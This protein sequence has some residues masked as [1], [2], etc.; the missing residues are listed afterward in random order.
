MDLPILSLTVVTTVVIVINVYHPS[1]V[2]CIPILR[3]PSDQ[4]PSS[5][6]NVTS[7]RVRDRHGDT[8][9]EI[10][11]TEAGKPREETLQENSQGHSGNNGHGISEIPGGKENADQRIRE[12]SNSSAEPDRVLEEDGHGKR[13]N[14]DPAD[15]HGQQE[16]LRHGKLE[17]EVNQGE[18]PHTATS[19]ASEHVFDS[20]FLPEG[21]H[22]ATSEVSE[23]VSDSEVL[24]GISII[25]RNGQ[26]GSWNR[27]SGA[28]QINLT[29]RQENHATSRRTEAEETDEGDGGRTIQ[30]EHA[31]EHNDMMD[32]LGRRRD[33][34]SDIAEPAHLEERDDETQYST[35]RAT[36]VP[37]ARTISHSRTISRSED[38]F[39]NNLPP[40]L[41]HSIRTQQTTSSAASA[42]RIT[43]SDDAGWDASITRRR[44]EESATAAPPVLHLVETLTA[45]HPSLTIRTAV[46]VTSLSTSL[47]RQELRTQDRGPSTERGGLEGKSGEISQAGIG[48]PLL[49]FNPAER[50]TSTVASVSA[51]LSF[52]TISFVPNEET[53]LLPS[54]STSQATRADLTTTAV[55]SDAH[56]L[57]HTVDDVHPPDLYS[58]A[59]QA[60]A[61]HPTVDSSLYRPEDYVH[62][63]GEFSPS[64][65]NDSAAQSGSVSEATVAHDVNVTRDS[66]QLTTV[67]VL[68]PAVS[69]TDVPRMDTFRHVTEAV[70]DENSGSHR[71][72]G[73]IND[74]TS[75][76]LQSLHMTTTQPIQLALPR[77]EAPSIDHP[78]VLPSNSNATSP[79]MAIT[80][81]TITSSTIITSTLA[82]IAATLAQRAS[83]SPGFAGLSSSRT[84]STSTMTSLP[85]A[86]SAVS[87]TLSASV[88]PRARASLSPVSTAEHN[89]SSSEIADGRAGIK[90]DGAK[91]AGEEGVSTGSARNTSDSPQNSNVNSTTLGA[92]FP[93]RLSTLAQRTESAMKRTPTLPTPRADMTGVSVNTRGAEHILLTQTTT[94]SQPQREEGDVETNTVDVDAQKKVTSGNDQREGIVTAATSVLF[95]TALAQGSTSPNRSA[96]SSPRSLPSTRSDSTA[97]STATRSNR[98]RMHTTFIIASTKNSNFTRRFSAEGLTSQATLTT[99]TTSSITE[100]GGVPPGLEHNGPFYIEIKLQMTWGQFCDNVNTFRLEIVSIVRQEIRQDS[101]TGDQIRLLESPRK[102]CALQT[103]YRGQSG[104]LFEEEQIEIQLYLVNKTYHYDVMLTYNCGLILRQGFQLL[105]ES[106]FKDKLILV[107]L[108]ELSEQDGLET[109]TPIIVV[110]RQDDRDKDTFINVPGVTIVISIAAVGGICCATLIIIQVVLRRRHREG[111]RVFNR[112]YSVTSVDSI[113]LNNVTKSRPNSGLFNPALDIAPERLPKTISHLLNF[114]EL[115]KFAFNQESIFEEFQRITNKTPRLSVVP[116]GAEDKNRFANILPIASTRVVLN[117][118]DGQD[119]VAAYINGN[120]VSGYSGKVRAYVAT[121]APLDNTLGDLWLMVW[122]HDTKTLVMLINPV[123]DGNK[124]CGTYFPDSVGPE[125]AVVCGDFSITMTKRDVHQ[126]Y[127]TSWLQVKM[128]KTKET[129]NVRHFWLTCWPASGR[130]DPISLVRFVLDSRPHYEDSGSPLLVHCSNGIARTGTFIALDICMRQFE[131][132]RTVDVMSCVNAMRHERAGCV[133]TSEQYAILYQALYEYATILTCP[134]AVSASS[135]AVTLT[136]LTS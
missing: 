95:T 1:A 26:G 21:A 102:A 81:T 123:E 74:R 120:Y 47:R 109:P 22:T 113:A 19:P 61:S 89:A 119:T 16:V 84:A 59:S 32:G 127:I 108:H 78:V 106:L 131:D 105:E 57:N 135:S 31:G 60:S 90:S 70:S 124:K 101:F 67:L 107:R 43:A 2:H 25:K 27:A 68:R 24:P 53:P 122:Q 91:E 103:S 104:G 77:T 117:V 46:G 94:G 132:R 52:S 15:V 41:D 51:V 83:T 134:P 72:A 98:S 79:F 114:N 99:R 18:D 85:S 35:G 14:E 80:I 34:G 28:V 17:D 100:A 126:E 93:F 66:V 69:Q 6:N 82:H 64:K 112:S 136:A 125:C 86:T 42:L 9:H 33:T 133:Q 40:V 8:A 38:I 76:S 63:H 44:P 115:V 39:A 20:E 75:D 111:V 48:H 36:A 30:D 118:K 29:G 49:P 11:L 5:H 37:G 71:D 128:I 50:S 23:H 54:S 92:D 121:Q 10:H 65:I 4:P 55:L 88:K 13:T 96:A 73:T 58:N 116:V 62:G 87:L 129:R 56:V 3:P 110:D 130:P 97:G 7:S 45:G 12:L